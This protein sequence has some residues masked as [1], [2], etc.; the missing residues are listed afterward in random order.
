MVPKDKKGSK[1]KKENKTDM[2]GQNAKN[3]EHLEKF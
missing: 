3:R 2:I 1:G